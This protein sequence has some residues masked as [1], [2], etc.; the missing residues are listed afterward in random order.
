M[1]LLILS[2]YDRQGASSRQRMLQFVPGL[3]QQ[4]WQVTIQPLHGPHYLAALYGG[5][6]R[7]PVDL[8]GDYARRFG[9]LAGAGRFD[10]VWAEKE[11][12]PWLPW[13]LERLL[14]PRAPLVVD[15]DDAVFHRYDQHQRALV[16]TLLGGKIDSVMRRADLVVAGNDYLAERAA[17]AGARRVAVLPTVIDEAQFPAP[18]LARAG[19]SDLPFTIG[20]IGTPRT[21]DYL[22]MIGGELATLA[23]EGPLKLVTIGASTELPGVPCESRPWSEAAEA[24]ELA[25]CDVGIMPLPDGP[26]ERG[27]CGY[28]LVQYMACGLPVVA[29]PVGINRTI[30]EHGVTGLLAA[31]GAAW[32]AALRRLRDDLASRLRLGGAG[33]ARAL[34][35]Y[36]LATVQPRLVDLLVSVARRSESVFR[37]D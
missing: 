2:R 16:R 11:L 10:L 24:A 13:P 28:K 29:S 12:V 25:Q 15:Y 8:A 32:L 22:G 20:W 19:R 34:A 31:D 14:T 21:V 23:G 37:S 26:W 36:S 3:R 27:K 35:D 1:R 6:Q 4:G 9:A 30:V 18:T 17:S 5:G 33:R 7:S